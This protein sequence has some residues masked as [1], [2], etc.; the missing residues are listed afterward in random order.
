MDIIFLLIPLALVLVALVIWGFFWAV[1][2]G[3]FEDLAGSRDLGA[4]WLVHLASDR[5]V[6]P[7]FNS[8]ASCGPGVGAYC[9]G[10]GCPADWF[11]RTGEVARNS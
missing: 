6:G 7:R 2:R 11:T 3:H 1:R 4:R 10:A 8:G 5:A 9:S